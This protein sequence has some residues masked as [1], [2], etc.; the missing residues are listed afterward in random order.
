M[1]LGENK[2]Y[3][4][5]DRSYALID[6]SI[7]N[8]VYKG[9]EFQK[10]TVLDDELLTENEKSEAIRIITETYDYS[11]LIRNEGTKRICENCNQECL[12]TTYC[13]ICVQ[14]YLKENFSNWTSGNV[15]IDNLIQECQMKAIAPDLIPEWIPYDSFKNIKYL[16]KGGFSE[17]YT[18]IWINGRFIEWNSERQQLKRLGRQIVILKRL[19]NVEY[20]NQ[21]WFEEAK[22][23]LNISNKWSQVVQ[24][25]GLTQDPSNGNYMLVM[26]YMN[27]DL[28][29]YLQQNHKKLTW[30]ERIQIITY[31]INAL[32]RIHSE[33]AIHRDL[34]SGNIL[35][36]TSN[37]FDISDLGFCGPADKPLKSVYGNLPY[38]APEVIIGKE[39]T[40]KS[41]IYSI[42]MLMWEV[43]SGQPPFINYEHDYDLAM[44]IVNGIRPKIVPGTPLEYKN[45]M[46]QCWDADP[47]KRPDIVTIRIKINEINLFYQSKSNESLTQPVDNNNFEMENY[48]SN[49]KLFTSK[50]HQ[51]DNLPNPRNATEEEQE[52]FHSNKSYDFHI[53]NNIDD[54]NKLN[55]KKNS[56][57]KISTIFKAEKSYPIYLKEAQK[58][59]NEIIKSILITTLLTL[60]MILIYL[61]IQNDFKIETM[62]Q[63][64]KQLHIDDNDK[65]EV[66]NNP[67]LHSEEQ[68]ELELPEK[69]VISLSKFVRFLKIWKYQEFFR[70]KNFIEFGFEDE[71]EELD[72]DG[73]SIGIKYY[74]NRDHE[75]YD[76]LHSF[77]SGEKQKPAKK[78]DEDDE[79]PE[80]TYSNATS[81]DHLI[82]DNV[83]YNNIV[84]KYL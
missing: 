53:P 35:S 44:N 75:F 80:P 59:A 65:G 11:K 21:S 50:L 39:Q 54:F 18:A 81:K 70:T 71:D 10:Q 27:I 76:G 84:G 29:K 20:A 31:I 67:N 43:S 52:A 47:S 24:C 40:F 25:F 58:M 13:E 5:I 30:K 51:F 38:I 1:S 9:Y 77:L 49:S 45:L 7:R 78:Y 8:N 4:A 60:N 6:S 12:A 82:M 32:E 68:D 55:S 36:K 69:F 62:Q 41:D 64:I 63:Q 23:H 74:T 3:N 73:A 46:K 34:H 19:E 16:T 48:I 22:S 2:I 42:A 57:S 15:I 28:R 72:D 17:I 33:N 66:H 79:D 26:Q 61:D 83:G 37:R 14:N 56:T